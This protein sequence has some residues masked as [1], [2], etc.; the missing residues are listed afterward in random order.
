MASRFR[1]LESLSNANA[2]A[3]P[4]PWR[5]RS[6]STGR[7]AT[8][9]LVPPPDPLVET[10][11]SP[12][13]THPLVPF[14]LESIEPPRL[15]T[16]KLIHPSI[17]PPE[18]APRETASLRTAPAPAADQEV[19]HTGYLTGISLSGILQ[20]LH[21]ERNSC[22][23]EVTAGGRLGTL[24]MVNGELIDAEV[25]DRCGDA[26]AMQILRWPFPV[27]AI[28]LSAALVRHSVNLPLTQLLMDSV[29]LQDEAIVLPETPWVDDG[30]TPYGEPAVPA[31]WRELPGRLVG[32][33]VHTA[34][35]MTA[36]SD[37]PVAE[38]GASADRASSTAAVARGIRTW[39]SLLVDGVDRVHVIAGARRLV[40]ASLTPDNDA[41][42]YLEAPAEMPLGTVWQAIADAA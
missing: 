39:S 24:T 37:E 38:A 4:I 27:T 26:V 23:L 14:S 31:P 30:P 21:M 36:S 2:S 5:D 29:R 32:L 20:M 3:A 19:R 11:Q 42:V 12:T 16:G 33:G 1:I 40:L 34:L 7:T 35:V 41:F 17:L 8:Y 25:E 22:V 6:A 9:D 28:L 10:F 18:T 15:G 13:G